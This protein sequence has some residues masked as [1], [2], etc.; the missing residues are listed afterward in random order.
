MSSINILNDVDGPQHAEQKE[1]LHQE[2]ELQLEEKGQ[3]SLLSEVSS[4]VSRPFFTVGRS[5]L[6]RMVKLLGVLF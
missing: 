2:D 3:V 6:G 1:D 4:K 5:C